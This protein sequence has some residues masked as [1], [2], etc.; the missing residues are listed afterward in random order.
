MVGRR[1][2]SPRTPDQTLH[3]ARCTQG[4]W[5][6][7]VNFAFT[8][9]RV[10][11]VFDSLTR[12]ICDGLGSSDPSRR[13]NLVFYANSALATLDDGPLQ[14]LAQCLAPQGGRMD[15]SGMGGTVGGGAMQT[16]C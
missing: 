13:A 4:S 5:T 7:R 14:F 16:W 11:D 12:N 2:S 6:D 8:L 3:F 10:Y 9:R 1:A 15:A